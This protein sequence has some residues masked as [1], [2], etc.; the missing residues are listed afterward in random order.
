MKAEFMGCACS[1]WDSGR[2]DFSPGVI[3]DTKLQLQ[4]WKFDNVEQT[5]N[6]GMHVCIYVPTNKI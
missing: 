2:Q 5:D 6:I 3:K 4:M 1:D